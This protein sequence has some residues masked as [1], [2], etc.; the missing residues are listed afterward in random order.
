MLYP[1]N[2]WSLIDIAPIS[3]FVKSM[4]LYYQQRI[5][6]LTTL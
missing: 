2:T 3:G 1:K 6:Q 4:T 5:I